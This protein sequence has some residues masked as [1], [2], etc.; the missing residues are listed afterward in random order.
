MN[1]EEYKKK[2][3]KLLE[4]S[5]E[6]VAEIQGKIDAARE[7]L[8][9]LNISFDKDFKEGNADSCQRIRAEIRNTDDDIAMLEKL[10]NTVK[11][12]PL[13]TEKEFKDISADLIQKATAKN[14]AAVK[15]IA[16][17]VKQIIEIGEESK[18]AADECNDLLTTYQESILR[19][20]IYFKNGALDITKKV[21]YKG[22]SASVMANRIRNEASNYTDEIEPYYEHKLMF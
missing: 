9:Q 5:R 12:K 3:A 19:Q 13:I 22:Y 14:I 18:A 17:L 21:S 16:G 8:E 4:K 2:A 20:N 10:L 11:N 15:K 7:K 6:A 1:N